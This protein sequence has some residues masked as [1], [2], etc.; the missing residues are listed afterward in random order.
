[1][2]DTLEDLRPTIADILD[3]YARTGPF[4]W[5]EPL[6][7]RIHRGAETLRWCAEYESARERPAEL[8]RLVDRVDKALELPKA[9]ELRAE[10][11]AAVASW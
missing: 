6:A 5:I 1:M 8:E 9:A 10:I 4:S 2:T 7:D 11:R 3:G